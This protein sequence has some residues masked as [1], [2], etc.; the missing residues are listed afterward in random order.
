MHWLGWHCHEQ[1]VAGSLYQYTVKITPLMHYVS[2]LCHQHKSY[3]AQKMCNG[4]VK[5]TTKQPRL[6]AIVQWCV[7]PCLATL[8]ECQMFLP[9][10]TEGDHWDTLALCRWRLFSKIWNRVISPRMKNGSESSTLETRDAC[11][12]WW[13]WPIWIAVASVTTINGSEFIVVHHSLN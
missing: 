10:R 7:S 12:K 6:S 13:W 5:W 1:Y 2:R 8:C 3:T 11:Q 4:D 9:W